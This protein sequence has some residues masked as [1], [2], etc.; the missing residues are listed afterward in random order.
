MDYVYRRV[1]SDPKSKHTPHFGHLEGDGDFILRTPNGEHLPG[2]PQHDFLVKPVVERPEPLLDVPSAPVKPVFAE[3]NGY[4]DPQNDSFGRNELSQKLG[5]YVRS[6]GDVKL[7][8]PSHWLSLV[9]EP[10][11]SQHVSLDIA[12]LAK[13]LRNRTT[14]SDKPCEPFRMPSLVFTTA[15]AVVLFEPHPWGD[16]KEECWTRFLRIEK[17]GAMEYCDYFNVAR[18]QAPKP[19]ADGIKL[20]KYVQTI[21]TIWTF[22]H[23]TK[24]VL[25]DADYHEG[26]RFLVNLMGTKDSMLVQFATNPGVDGKFW[27]QPFDQEAL[28]AGSL[29]WKCRDPNLQIPFKLVLGSLGDAESKKVIV[30]CAEQLGLAYNHQSIP[31]CF[32]SGT[33]VFPWDQFRSG[34]E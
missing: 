33:D 32:T 14:K 8:R 29:N 10:V 15:S 3:K 12:D 6:Q 7:H 24:Q 1:G 20:F 2:G 27:R 5:F 19:D 17:T 30:E 25:G 28:F 34:S 11:S 16:N 23:A 21:G 4:A 31:R 18:V 13:T 26:V 22:L 9:V